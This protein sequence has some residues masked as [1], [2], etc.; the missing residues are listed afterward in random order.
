MITDMPIGLARGYRS[1]A[2]RARV[3]SEAWAGQNLFCPCCPSPRLN[4]LDPNVPA[5][6]MFCP[7]C[8][9][10]FQLKSQRRPP[11]GRV[12]DSAYNSMMHAIRSDAA[13]N[14]LVLH[15]DRDRWQVRDL[16]LIPRFALSASC[17][18]KRRPL[19]PN[20]RRSGWVGCNILL[21][22]IPVDARIPLVTAGVPEKASWVRERYARLQPL[23]G[24]RHEVRGWMLDV[25]RFVRKLGTEQ[26]TL[27]DVYSFR[28]QLAA[29]HPQ[30][31]HVEAKI[32]QQLQRLRDAGLVDFMG[33]GNYALRP[34]ARSAVNTSYTRGD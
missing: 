15:Y 7:R 27:A 5:V 25:L 31:L 33:G 2:Q 18:E 20:A 34:L 19:G 14:L 4:L 22:S 8:S 6:D 13:P 12:T 32:R 11:S 16:L 9:S 23:E 3:V 28:N 30:N 10:A 29:L 1:P 21:A 24:Q 26:F 17:I